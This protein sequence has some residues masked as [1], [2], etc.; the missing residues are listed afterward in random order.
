MSLSL[1]IT[2]HGI[3]P[4]D[5]DGSQGAHN[6]DTGDSYHPDTL[7]ILILPLWS[8][9][10]ELFI[11]KLSIFGTHLVMSIRLQN[12]SIDPQ[13][14]HVKLFNEYNDTYYYDISS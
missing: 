13:M 2:Y 4:V 8:S 6:S 12:L 14:D 10:Y 3:L 9:S 1:I 11:I 5:N 7:E